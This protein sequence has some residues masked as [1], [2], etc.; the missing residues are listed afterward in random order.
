M[1]FLALDAE[2]NMVGQG[3]DHVLPELP[4]RAVVGQ[5]H[6]GGGHLHNILRDAGQQTQLLGA[7]VIKGTVDLT[8]RHIVGRLHEADALAEGNHLVV[9]AIQTEGNVIIDVFYHTH[10]RRTPQTKKSREFTQYPCMATERPCGKGKP[11][12]SNKPY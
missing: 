5:V 3:E 11:P 12:E 7:D 9:V 1:L 2:I 10:F 8:Q 4:V 6:D